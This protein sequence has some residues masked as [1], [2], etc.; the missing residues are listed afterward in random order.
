MSYRLTAEETIPQGIRRIVYEQIDKAATELTDDALSR[1]E[2]VHQAR[3]RF[4]K[5]RGVL[6]LVRPAL[7]EVYQA[8]NTCYRD[9]GRELSRIRD[10]TAL[11]ET[12]DRLH[13]TYEDYLDADALQPIRET[14]VERRQVIVDE[15]EDLEERIQSV[16]AGLHD[17]R[18]RVAD[19]PLTTDR[20]SSLGPGLKKTYRRGRKAFAKAYETPTAERFHEWRKRVKYHWYHTRLLQNVWS[21]LMKSYRR[22]LKDLSDLLGYHHDFAVFRRTL[23]D[24]PDA[25]GGRRDLQVLLGLIDRRRLELEARS[26]PLGQRIFTEKPEHMHTRIHAYWD[27]WRKE[28]RQMVLLTALSNSA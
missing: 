7:G 25:F 12:Y 16:Q 27:A 13:D 8:E 28:T 11:I 19:W 14:L 18:E 21:R 23:L 17:A 20:F 2:S 6:R 5:I 3:K 24:Q 9:M 10:A 1:H 26:E 15:K 4:K 22:S